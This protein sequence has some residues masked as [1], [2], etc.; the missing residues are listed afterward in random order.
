MKKIILI[1]VLLSINSGLFSQFKK[2]E[3]EQYN[4]F[5]EKEWESF[6]KRVQK[7][8]IE[9]EEKLLQ[10]ENFDAVYYGLDLKIDVQYY[11]IYGK[12]TIKAKSKINGLNSVVLDLYDNMNITSVTG[13]VSSFTHSDNIITVTLD[14]T[15]NFDELIEI[16]VEYN[17][18]PS[19][20][21]FA[22][23]TFETHGNPP[24][25]IISSLSEPYYARAWWP[26]KD[27]PDDKAD[28]ADIIITV[29][30]NLIASSN[31]LLRKITDNGD[32]TVTYSW[33]EKYPITTYLISVAVSNYQ[34]SS[35]YY[36]YNNGVDTM[37]VQY[38]VYPEYTGQSNPGIEKCVDMIELYSGLYGQYPFIEEKY[39][40]SQFSWGGAMEHQTNS[41][42]TN[43]GEMV[44]AHE[45]AHQWWGD[46]IT[47]SDWHNI[48][49]NEGFATYSEAL[50]IENKYS[51]DSYVN[52]VKHWSD[53]SYSGSIYIDDV[54]YVWD[55]FNRI[56]YSKAAFV[57]H[58]LR[59]IVGDQTFFNILEEYRERFIWQNASTEDFQQV[60]ED[61]YGQDLDWFFQQWIYGTG[62]PKYEYGWT[63]K[64]AG[65]SNIVYLRIK[66]TQ[67]SSTTFTMPITVRVYYDGGSKDFLIHNDER[68]EFYEFQ[69]DFNP[70]DLKID[71]DNFVLK[72]TEL[73]T[74]D[75]TGIGLD[76][77]PPEIFKMSQNY[78]NPF[79]NETKI[80]IYMIPGRKI[81]LKIYNTAGKLVKTLYEGFKGSGINVFTWD[82]TNDASKQVSSG[83]YFY[84]L[85]S[86]NYE[87]VKKMVLIK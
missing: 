19:E 75:T 13:D 25:P 82:G 44:T 49:I 52:Y 30:D 4:K 29:P 41:S 86:G 58:M 1:S 21:G 69:V 6:Q 23:F 9:P 34:I 27:L 57:L 48:W 72:N 20:E 31:G 35:D 67:S 45:L 70:I 51:Q 50:W 38:Y 43:F 32:G 42:M 66:Q 40:M 59:N 37:E 39:A 47:C 61:N 16:V 54:S 10:Q 63:Y 76:I 74:F 26:C 71:P 2:S 7:A 80:S 81:S 78:P 24:Q 8:L 60:C 84:R 36:I 62:R 53:R 15:Y 11:H 18:L 5:I 87:F 83:I 22:S 79:N 17:G 55:I 3:L 46:M 85:T 12:T 28:S 14:K 56:V 68:D 65:F 77:E 64:L 73:V 33:H